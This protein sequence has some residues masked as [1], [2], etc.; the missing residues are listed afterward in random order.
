MARNQKPYLYRYYY[1]VDSLSST[2]TKG[3]II[4]PLCHKELGCIFLKPEK[5]GPLHFHRSML[6]KIEEEVAWYGPEGKKQVFFSL[7]SVPITNQA[8]A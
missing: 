7:L 2:G 3:A 1:C 5:K 4:F 6:S 8:M